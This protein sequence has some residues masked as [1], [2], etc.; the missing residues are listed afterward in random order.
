M[1]RLQYN[2]QRLDRLLNNMAEI[3]HNNRE[4]TDIYFRRYGNGKAPLLIT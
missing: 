3:R 1:S 4:V 2:L